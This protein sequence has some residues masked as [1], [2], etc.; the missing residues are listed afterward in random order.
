MTRKYLTLSMALLAVTLVQTPAAA[1]GGRPHLH[2][3]SR[4]D[5]CSIQLHSSLSQAA[6][7]Q[8]TEEAG[9]VAYFRPLTDARPMGRGQFE[10]S[11]H[12]WETRIDD[13]DA[14]WNDTFVHPDSAHWLFEGSGLKFPGL[15][16]RAGVGSKTDVGV[17]FTK[18]P[19]ANYGFFGAQVQQN[20]MD[21]NQWSAATRLSFTSLFGPDDVDFAVLGFDIVGSRE[22]PVT[23]WASIA[24]YAGVSSYF[25]VARENSPVV[26]LESEAVGGSSAMVGAALQ[27]S[28]ARIALEYSNARVNSLALKVGFG[29]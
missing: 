13:R 21:R 29:R 20:L 22:I 24:P 8:F 1:Q 19:N 18:N 23:R 14:A 4:W 6:W 7:R 2:V 12:Q 16:V 17:Y 15:M 11:I 10:V 27:L 28:G 9:L 25:A 3:N 5:E 26:D